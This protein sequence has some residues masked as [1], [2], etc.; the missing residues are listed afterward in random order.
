[1]LTQSGGKFHTTLNGIASFSCRIENLGSRKVSLHPQDMK[2]S[3][4][5]KSKLVPACSS[6]DKKIHRMTKHVCACIFAPKKYTQK[7]GCI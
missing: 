4:N 3:Q 7:Y 5:D 1:M 6:C 2:N